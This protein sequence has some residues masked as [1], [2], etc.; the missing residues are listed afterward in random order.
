[1]EFKEKV[2]NDKLIGFYYFLLEGKKTKL[3]TYCLNEE[4]RVI[5]E[6]LRDVKDKIKA[7]LLS[8]FTKERKSNN[9]V[10]NNVYG[11]MERKN[12]PYVFK[13]FNK[14][15]EIEKRTKG[16]E[17]SKRSEVRGKECSSH[18]L[19]EIKT[20]G[21]L[22]DLKQDK[23]QKKNGCYELEYMLRKNDKI[24]LNNKIWFLNSIDF[25][26]NQIIIKN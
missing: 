5:T 13:I 19:E 12:G 16:D 4:T 26:K 24:K 20:L 22:L 3:K 23:I 9:L 6:C 17:K 1:M 21:K 10:L 15:K 7:R 18:S 8:K 14:T 25:V 11:F 2:S